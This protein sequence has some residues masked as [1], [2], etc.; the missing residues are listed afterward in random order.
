MF[1]KPSW[2]KI[3]YG[4]FESKKNLKENIY[5]KKK[6]QEYF[7]NIYKGI[8][9]KQIWTSNKISMKTLYN[10]VGLYK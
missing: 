8:K 1:G 4:N 10:I 6:R 7:S 2:R 3:L 5:H 9:I